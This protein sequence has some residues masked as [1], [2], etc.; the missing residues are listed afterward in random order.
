MPMP[1]VV[2]FAKVFKSLSL[3]MG[4]RLTKID[5]ELETEPQRIR[6]AYEVKADRIEP[7]GFVYLWPLSN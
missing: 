6:Q 2:N 5:R 4:D 3:E 7:V 1:P